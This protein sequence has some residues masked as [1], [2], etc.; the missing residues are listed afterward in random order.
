MLACSCTDREN[1][2]STRSQTGAE[3]IP[4][5]SGTSARPRARRTP[6]PGSGRSNPSSTEFRVPSVAG[7][8]V[9]DDDDDDGNRDYGLAPLA[10]LESAVDVGNTPRISVHRA[11]DHRPPETALNLTQRGASYRL[12]TAS[13][14]ERSALSPVSIVDMPD[15]E[16]GGWSSSDGGCSSK[17]KLI[18]IGTVV[19]VIFSILIAVLTSS[20]HTIE[21]GHVGIY[22]KHGALMDGVSFPGVHTMAPFVTEVRQVSIRPTTDSLRPIDAITRDGIANRFSEVQVKYKVKRPCYLFQL[23]S[24]I[25]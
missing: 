6:S 7:L 21:E 8:A 16:V 22:F 13:K 19:V 2:N 5:A 1:R 10:S 15:E 14:E 11:A 23:F 20:I 9:K 25:C 17:A 12:A 24:H 3:G 18:T 4:W